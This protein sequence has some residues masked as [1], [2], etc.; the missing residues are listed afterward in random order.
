MT[1]FEDQKNMFTIFEKLKITVSS[2]QSTDIITNVIAGIYNQHQ[3][4]MMMIYRHSTY[5]RLKKNHLNKMN[6]LGNIKW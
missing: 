4:R 2:F 6:I 5:F 1:I 3:I